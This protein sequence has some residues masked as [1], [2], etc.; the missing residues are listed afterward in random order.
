MTDVIPA[1]PPGATIGPLAADWTMATWLAADPGPLALPGPQWVTI[2]RIGRLGTPGEDREGASGWSLY[3]ECLMGEGSD[4]RFLKPDEA[5]EFVRVWLGPFG[6]PTAVFRA[7]T[8]GVLID[9]TQ[10]PGAEPVGEVRRLDD[11]WVCRVAIPERSVDA[12]G[13]I[14][15]G[16]ERTDARGQHS[17]WPRP[18]LPWQPEPGRAAI[19]T[20]AWG[21]LVG[22]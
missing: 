6:R 22:P 13:T 3:L 14:R 9:E 15:V 10:G 18:M 4:G 11:R 17:A 5:G 12:D 7:T 16:V 21:S 1:L 8:A 19:S 20:S 2:G